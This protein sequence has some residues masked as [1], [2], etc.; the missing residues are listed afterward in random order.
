MD[1]DSHGGGFM[2]TIKVKDWMVTLDE[3]TTLS[4]D[5]TLY[6][7]VLA[8]EAAKERFDVT[9]DR[10]PA[11]IVLEKSGHA[12]G[13]LNQLDILRCLEPKYAEMGDLKKIAGYGLSADLLRS[14]IDRYELWKAPLNEICRKA[15]RMRIGGITSAPLAGEFIEAEASINQALHQLIICQDQSLMVTSKGKTVGILLLTD[16]F[17]KVGALIKPCEA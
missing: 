7:A 1:N 13:K 6:E 12:V 2:E 11:V 8:L 15:S 9:G 10:C 17:H 4:E 3:C 16:V 5:A 14:M